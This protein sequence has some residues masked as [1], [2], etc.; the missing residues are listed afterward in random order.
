MAKLTNVLNTA[1]STDT[2]VRRNSPIA[3]LPLFLEKVRRP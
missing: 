2:H 1:S 3:S